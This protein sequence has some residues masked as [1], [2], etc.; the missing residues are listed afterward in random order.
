MRGVWASFA[1]A[2][3]FLTIIPLPGSPGAVTTPSTFASS[4][5]WF[6]VVGFLL[7]AGLV[8]VDRV[9]GDSLAPMAL[10]LVLLTLYVLV[11]GGLHQDGLADTVDAFAG[12][13]TPEDRLRILRDSHI[14]A[15]G[16]TGLIL[17]L[18]LRYV[19]LMSLPVGLRE[20]MIL[21]MPAIGRWAMVVGAWGGVYPRPEGLA[22]PFIRNMSAL[23]VLVASTVV[24]V[25]L[26]LLFGPMAALA[27][28]I[29]GSMVIRLFVWWVS[30]KMGGVTGDIL[31]SINEGLEILFVSAAPALLFLG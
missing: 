8:M 4:L 25:G 9:L 30:R 13:K 3:Q 7:G 26:F 23:D 20:S 5:R 21:C 14:G 10:N 29:M 2:W 17:S 27:L 11:T 24:W 16:A 12:G 19:G 22:A 18:G 6:P 15:L 31:G 28:L 1:L